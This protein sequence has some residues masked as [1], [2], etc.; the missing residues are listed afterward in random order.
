MNVAVYAKTRNVKHFYSLP[1]LT[2]HSLN[3]SPCLTHKSVPFFSTTN[4]LV[5]DIMNGL[6]LEVESQ[7]E[8][9]M[10]QWSI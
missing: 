2:Q 7:C 8:V 6:I 5:Y 10:C 4:I 1:D 9:L 3:I